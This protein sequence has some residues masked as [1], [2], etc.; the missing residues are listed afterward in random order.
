MQFDV[1]VMA[2]I[3][4]SD[5]VGF[6][7]SNGLVLGSLRSNSMQR[8]WCC[9]VPVHSTCPQQTRLTAQRWSAIA[10]LAILSFV[11]AWSGL[12][13]CNTSLFM[14]LRCKPLVTVI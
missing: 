11:H 2:F 3:D 5:Y 1:Q 4:A 8:L 12:A 7:S 13:L 14:L 6:A 9:T 10:V